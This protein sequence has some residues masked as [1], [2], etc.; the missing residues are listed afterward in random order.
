MNLED[1]IE[2]TKRCV[3][4]SDKMHKSRVGEIA[5]L[6]K[7]PV[8]GKYVK[9]KSRVMFHDEKNST[10]LGD[11]VLIREGAPR[12]KRKSFELVSILK[13]SDY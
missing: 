9:R 11:E 3:V 12:S 4:V 6:V 8:V 2:R 1:A 5:R 13:K 7:H 10:S